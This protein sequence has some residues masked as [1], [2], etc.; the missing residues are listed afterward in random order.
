[1]ELSYRELEGII[2]PEYF[3]ADSVAISGKLS[4]ATDAERKRV[5]PVVIDP[6]GARIRI[7]VEGQ[8]RQVQVS[9]VFWLEGTPIH[10][11]M[12]FSA[13]HLEAED[14]LEIAG[15]FTDPNRSFAIEFL[16]T[17]GDLE[18]LYIKNGHLSKEP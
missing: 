2:Q 13:S 6:A 3:P 18:V 4:I 8:V 9:E 17:G 1:M 5:I 14:V 10:K 16:N 15:G 11:Q 7:G 12:L